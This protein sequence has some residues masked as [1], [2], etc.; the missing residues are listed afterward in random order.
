M[1]TIDELEIK[2]S[3]QSTEA[4]KGIDTLTAALRKLKTATQGGS[5]LNNTSNQLSQ[6]SEKTKSLALNISK[7]TAA[8]VAAKKVGS[9]IGGWIKESNDYVENL[10]LFTV[11]MGQYANE[12]QNYAEIVGDAMGI[13]PSKWMRYQGVFMTLATG[14][15]V[16][17]DR[18]A[19]M[20]RNLTQLSYDISSFYNKSFEESMN[21]IRSGF[22]GEIEPVRNLGYDLSQA[23]LQAIALENGITKAFSAMTQAEKSQLRYIALMTQVTQVQGDMART[24][25][26]PANQLRVLSASATQAARALGNIFIPMLNKILPYATA[27]MKVVRRLADR[28]ANLFGFEI[29]EVD[30]SGISGAAASA[31]D[32]S[33]TVDDAT[34]SVKKFKNELLGIDEINILGS[35]QD[36]SSVGDLSSLG[37]EIQFSLPEY[38]FLSGLVE[39]NTESISDAIE[40]ALDN[41]LPILEAASLVVGAV[42]TFTG[43]PA[44]GIPLMVAGAAGLA[45][46]AALDY[47]YTED[48]VKSVLS[49]IANI[50]SVALLAVGAVLAFTGA[51]VP[52]G[53]AL[54]V[55]GATAL[56]TNIALNWN[57]ISHNVKAV[58]SVIAGIVGAAFL[59]LGAILTFGG[60]NLPIGIA[61]LAAGASMLISAVAANWDWLKDNI[62]S[63]LAAMFSIVS[64]ATLVLGVLLLFSGA[65]I[66]LGLGLIAAGATGIATAATWDDNVVTKKISGAFDRARKS[67]ETWWENLKSWWKKLTL[68]EFKVKKLKLSWTAQDIDSSDWKYKILSALGLPVQ[69]P[70]LNVTWYAGGGYPSVGELFVAREA[71]PEMVGT[72][73]GRSAVVNN[74]Q[75]IASLEGGVERGFIK[76]MSAGFGG[77]IT[78]IIQTSDGDIIQKIKRANAKAGKILVPVDL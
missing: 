11:S 65:G 57:G 7:V 43:H 24:L 4:A 34:K 35:Q 59:V 49:S 46:S 56:A 45:I 78:I 40:T 47:K 15:G 17:G 55:V 23:K 6:V 27:A 9:V 19:V 16:A 28:I 42:L 61:L 18:A 72:I 14:F 30:Y 76:A 75:I 62:K 33:D 68:P 69:I 50:L 26:A 13:D 71:G 70:K 1:P 67:I 21:A 51:N 64:V 3:S 37:G 41:I 53:V 48:K 10:N 8:V 29:Q 44:I 52:I 74:E 25:N 20:S 2:I 54:M 22:S 66:A 12:A 31:S 73:G 39:S 36:G 77:D 60:I 58:I 63:I 38:N 5:G 32:V